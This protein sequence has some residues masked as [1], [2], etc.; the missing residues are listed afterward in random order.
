MNWKLVYWIVIIKRF[1]GPFC[2]PQPHPP[3]FLQ[4]NWD[5]YISRFR[6]SVHIMFVCKIFLAN[7]FSAE[8]SIYYVDIEITTI[9]AYATLQ[10]TKTC[11]THKRNLRID[12]KFRNKLILSISTELC[13]KNVML[14]LQHGPL[15][16]IRIN[17]WQDKKMSAM[18]II[19]VSCQQAFVRS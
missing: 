4:E 19:W 16:H 7:S 13:H 10:Y 5:F 17:G 9:I 8:L 15:G 3:I 2:D 14:G 18:F 6:L 11:M 12:C 1:K